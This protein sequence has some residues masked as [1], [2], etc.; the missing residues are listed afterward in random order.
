[1]A[2]PLAMSKLVWRTSMRIVELAERGA[3]AT[4][5][6]LTLSYLAEKNEARLLQG[7]YNL[8][9]VDDVVKWCVQIHD[10]DVRGVL[11]WERSVLL[12]WK[13]VFERR[14]RGAR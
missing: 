10:D 12:L 9:G 3:H 6:D 5:V 14:A 11:L 4:L 13:K 8:D 1:M 7:F 2:A